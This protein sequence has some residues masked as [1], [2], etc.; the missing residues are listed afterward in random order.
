G[1]TDIV[2][3][4]EICFNISNSSGISLSS[5]PLS[6]GFGVM[7]VADV[8]GDGLL[9]LIGNNGSATQLQLQGAPAFSTIASGAASDLAVLD[10]DADGD[11]DLVVVNA[12]S[13]LT[14]LLMNDG[15]GGL[16]ASTSLIPAA[17]GRT[18][19]AVGDVN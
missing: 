17:A 19:V 6:A 10:A 3:G 12:A 18:A 7:V 11:A 1:L 13:S 9:D 2:T 4:S 15:M 14:T 5:L 8:N 16:S